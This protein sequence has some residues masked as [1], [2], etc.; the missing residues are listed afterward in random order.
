MEAGRRRVRRTSEEIRSLILD[1]ARAVF[2]E[3][4][5]AGG[6]TRLIAERASVAE[7]LIFNNFGGKAALFDEAVIQPF[8][9]RFTDFLAISDDLPPDREMRSAQFV[10]AVYPF[11]RDNA[12][13]LHALVKSAGDMQ[14]GAVPGLDDYFTRAADRM[15]SQ[16]ELRGLCFDVAPELV[17]RYCFGMLAGSVLLSDWFFPTNAPEDSVAEGALARLLY[18]ASE[19]RDPEREN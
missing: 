7:P 13:L 5:F 10:H 11:L 1:A 2:A 19:P 14:V 16:Y 17:V 15:R 9:L 12:D 8:N 6:T 4:G 3:R 18:K